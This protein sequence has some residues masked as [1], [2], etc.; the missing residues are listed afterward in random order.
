MTKEHF[1]DGTTQ[2]FASAPFA[3]NHNATLPPYW[4]G[5]GRFFL[6]PRKSQSAQ[7]KCKCPNVMTHFFK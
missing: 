1:S 4:S 5:L 7:V 6:R 2:W 3:I